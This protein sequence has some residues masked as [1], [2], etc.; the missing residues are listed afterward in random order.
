MDINNQA[1]SYQGL[2]NMLNGKPA[3]DSA[4]TSQQR[5]VDS[6]PHSGSSDSVS[7]SYKGAKLGMISA[8]Y[9]SGTVKSSD[10]PAL[11]ERL[12]QDGFI[13]ETEYRALGGIKADESTSQIAQSVNFLNDFI[14]GEAV[15]GDSEGAKS[16]MFAVDALQRMDE[17]STE[18]SRRKESEAYEFVSGYTEILKETQAPAD[19]V[20]SF[21]QVLKVFEALDTVRKN[22]LQTGALASYA[23]VQDTYDEYN[24]PS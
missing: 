1:Q 4:A 13:N 12:Y 18:D 3:N 11:T 22:E 24:K 5:I 2:L 15:D 14:M 6:L 17:S 8:E 16:L 9:F 7:L 10:I 20:K 23:S 21:E 19:L